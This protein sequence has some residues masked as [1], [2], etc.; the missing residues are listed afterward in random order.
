MARRKEAG[1][2]LDSAVS[3]R[4]VQLAELYK[5]VEEVIGSAQLAR[6]WMKMPR[7]VFKDRTPFEL[8]TTELGACEVED[9]LLRVEHGVFYWGRFMNVWRLVSPTWAV[10]AFD[11]EGSRRTGGRW[12]S[13]GV[14]VVY[15]ASSLS[16][17]AL[18]LLVRIDYEQALRDYVAIQVTCDDELVLSVSPG[19][20]PKYWMQPDHIPYTQNRGM[21]G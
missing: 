15:M 7:A 11:G 2:P 12:N 19:S 4:L 16:L 17:A 18:E 1:K 9:V 8:E 21:P 6:Q 14:P 13:K 20:L 10:T 3:E 5:K